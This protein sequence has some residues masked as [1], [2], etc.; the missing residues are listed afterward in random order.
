MTV[1]GTPACAMIADSRFRQTA[2]ASAL[3]EYIRA[4]AIVIPAVP[5]TQNLYPNVAPRTRGRSGVCA[6]MNWSVLT[7]TLLFELARFSP[8]TFRYHASLATPNDASQVVYAGFA[9]RNLPVLMP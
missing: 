5:I 9:K 3:T 8:Y 4:L 1:V 6:S 2:P 7:K